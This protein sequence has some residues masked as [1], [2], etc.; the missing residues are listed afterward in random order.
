MGLFYL[1]Y[2]SILS[3]QSPESAF[4]S[5]LIV[6]NRPDIASPVYM[7]DHVRSDHLN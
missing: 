3:T 5:S 1:E 4:V 6:R 2:G 7:N